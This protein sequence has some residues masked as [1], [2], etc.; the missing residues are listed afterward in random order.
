M[1][2]S[3]ATSAIL[4][5]IPAYAG[6]LFVLS[7]SPAVAFALKP[8]CDPRRESLLRDVPTRLSAN[9]RRPFSGTAL[10]GALGENVRWWL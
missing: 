9:K 6:Y 5:E 1:F 2:L 8:V 4:G 7:S 3:P 10:N